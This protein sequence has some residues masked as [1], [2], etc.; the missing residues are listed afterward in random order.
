MKE[1]FLEDSRMWVVMIE[2]GRRRRREDVDELLDEQVLVWYGL[3]SFGDFGLA[4][5]AVA[6]R[7]DAVPPT[8]AWQVLA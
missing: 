8:D 7:G 5:V 6:V 4:C 2:M 1:R 3:A